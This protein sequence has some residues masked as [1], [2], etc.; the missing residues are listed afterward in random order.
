MTEWVAWAATRL[1]QWRIGLLWLMVVAAATAAGAA[2]PPAWTL[3]A[4]AALV[5]Q[6]RLWDDL[7]DLP[8][9]RV[10][11]P[12][13]VLVRS[14]RPGAFRGLLWLSVAPIALAFALLQGWPR[15]AAYLLLLASAAAIYRTTDS[16]GA[17][18]RLRAQLVL[19]KY[20]AFVLL[21]A[22]QPAAWR[23]VAAALVLHAALALHEWHDQRTGSPS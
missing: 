14:T 5:V 18:R 23:A 15:L 22:E 10:H 17:R 7:A 8:H 2:E 1:L 3:L 11:A 16:L 12:Q 6:F 13:R 19:L 20:P 4:A 9:D 21:L